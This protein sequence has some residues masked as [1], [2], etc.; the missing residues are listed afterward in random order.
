MVYAH[1]FAIILRRDG[2]VVERWLTDANGMADVLGELARRRGGGCA[3]RN[4]PG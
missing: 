1:R 3:R 4:G 2:E